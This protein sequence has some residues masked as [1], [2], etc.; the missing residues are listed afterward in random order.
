MKHR[1]WVLMLLGLLMGLF[2]YFDLGR[3]ISLES[4]KNSMKR[5]SKPTMR[6]LCGSSPAMRQRTS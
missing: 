6:S 5:C 4:S 1:W 2:F 3:F